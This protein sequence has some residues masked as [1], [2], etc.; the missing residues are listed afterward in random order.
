MLR[1]ELIA[2]LPPSPTLAANERVQAKLAAGEPVLHLAFGEAGLP[3]L[4]AVAERLVE[5]AGRNRY[6]P[7]AGSPAAREAAAGY[8]ARRGV[9]TDA[10][11]I[12]FAPGSKPLLFALL[13]ALPGDVVLPVPCW[14]SYAA[15][16]AIA[17]KRVIGVPIGAEAAACPTPRSCAPRWPRRR[18]SARAPACSCSR[19]PTTRPAPSRPRRSSARSARSPTPRAC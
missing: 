13:Q 5:G 14:V 11:Q 7:V 9:P 17:G 18:A 15:H 1:S 2:A 10:G 16:A 8:F 12:V 4:P 19:C 6:G 3:V